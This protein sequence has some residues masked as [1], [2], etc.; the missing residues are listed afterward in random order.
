MDLTLIHKPK[1]G[2]ADWPAD[3][4]MAAVEG[5]GLRARYHSMDDEGWRRAAHDADGPVLVAGGDGTVE[6]VACALQGQSA[7]LAILPI[8]GSN[9]IARSYGACL[10][11]DKVLAGLGA[12]RRRS[13]H[14]CRAQGANGVH[15][16]V[17]SIGIGA[18]ARSS[19][20]LP[21]APT[22]QE[23]RD[24]GRYALRDGL[25]EARAVPA[26]VV[27]DGEALPDPA[28][29]VEVMNIAIVGPNLRLVPG[30]DPEAP[31]LT[32]TWLPTSGRQ[33]MVDWLAEPDGRAPPL[34]RRAARHVLFELDDEHLHV[35]DEFLP[36]VRGAVAVARDDTTL[37]LLVPE[38]AS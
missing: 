14:L 36:E 8:G 5:A 12:A 37:Q 21:D 6:R 24:R 2:E 16:F 9:N 11:P 4:V 23:K 20:R 7:A 18:L 26:R 19:M 29:L 22:R 10:P 3:R 33:A 13:L 38:A 25:R 17:E 27:V 35:A 28:L 1:A 31:H 30:W 15:C 32:V 34:R